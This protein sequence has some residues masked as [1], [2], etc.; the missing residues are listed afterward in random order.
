VDAVSELTPALSW[1]PEPA[2]FE[3]NVAISK[4]SQ[5]VF[6]AAERTKPKGA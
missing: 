6:F 3:V 2:L 1:T 5:I 4:M